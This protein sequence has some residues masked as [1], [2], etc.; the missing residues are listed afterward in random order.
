MIGV[1]QQ[2]LPISLW[3]AGLVGHLAALHSREVTPLDE[4]HV[5]EQ[6]ADGWKTAA[7]LK[8]DRQPCGIRLD[9]RAPFLAFLIRVGHQGRQLQRHTHS[10]NAS[11]TD[12][13]RDRAEIQRTDAG[14][15]RFA[16]A[17]HDHEKSLR[18]DIR[19]GRLG[20]ASAVTA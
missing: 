8:W 14:F 15:D 2:T 16:V 17:N 10:P 1:R 12:I 7:A 19:R 9:P 11:C 3:N 5:V 4:E 13:V 18:L 6:A 20:T